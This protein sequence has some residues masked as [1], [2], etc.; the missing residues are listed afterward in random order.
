MFLAIIPARSG[1]KRLKNKNLQKINNKPLIFY[2]I[3]EALKSK[4]ISDTIVL[5]D[6]KSIKRQRSFNNSY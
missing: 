1:S 5:T 6:S 2:A 3:R 4:F